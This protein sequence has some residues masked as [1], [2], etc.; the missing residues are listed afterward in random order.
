MKKKIFIMFFIM[1]FSVIAQAGIGDLIESAKNNKKHASVVIG[2][3]VIGLALLTE[4]VLSDKNDVIIWNLF[5][6][7]CTFWSEK[8]RSYIK[9]QI[10]TGN[11][12]LVST[13]GALW[14]ILAGE[15]VYWSYRGLD[16]WIENK[17]Q[18]RV[19][20]IIIGKSV[21]KEFLKKYVD[22]EFEEAKGS[23]H[24]LDNKIWEKKE[25]L[26]YLITK[27]SY[28]DGRLDEIVEK[29]KRF[30]RRWDDGLKKNEDRLKTVNIAH[31]II[32]KDAIKSA[33]A[34]DEKI[35]GIAAQVALKLSKNKAKK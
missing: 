23:L 7:F 13:V 4:A 5:K 10:S 22:K 26:R 19:D 33:Q 29:T 11:Y 8:S 15:S 3:S 16:K 35:D 12:R 2:G 9:E 18:K 17:A 25:T 21:D 31:D 27:I 6:S 20:E 14:L 1:L 24:D 30:E 28:C 32:K 34:L